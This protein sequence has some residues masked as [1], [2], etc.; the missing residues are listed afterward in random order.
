MLLHSGHITAWYSRHDNDILLCTQTSCAKVGSHRKQ[1]P[2]LCTANFAPVLRRFPLLHKQTLNIKTQKRITNTETQTLTQTRH[3]TNNTTSHTTNNIANNITGQEQHTHNPTT[4]AQETPQPCHTRNMDEHEHIHKQS[5][6]DTKQTGATTTPIHKTN[7][8]FTKTHTD[9]CHLQD[10]EEQ[11]HTYTHKQNI[12]KNISR[13]IQISETPKTCSS[14][15]LRASS[16]CV[17]RVTFLF[18]AL[19]VKENLP[20]ETVTL[21]NYSEGGER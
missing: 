9:N 13:Y 11:K 8:N 2:S 20:T 3:T 12:Y 1:F 10:L 16:T 5:K 18:L 4:Q 21:N 15:P 17:S 14:G 6:T 7:T 19:F